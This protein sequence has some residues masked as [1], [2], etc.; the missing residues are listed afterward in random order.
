[1]KQLYFFQKLTTFF[2]V[3]SY[4]LGSFF[5]LKSLLRNT[6]HSENHVLNCLAAIFCLALSIIFFYSLLNQAGSFLKIYQKIA[7]FFYVAFSCVLPS[8]YLIITLKTI[9]PAELIDI[10]LLAA[11]IIQSSTMIALLI[12]HGTRHEKTS[13][14][15]A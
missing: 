5:L 3:V 14:F 8:A 12:E 1:M 9:I 7:I 4:L 15:P 10:L 11:S 6:L 2:F 13:F